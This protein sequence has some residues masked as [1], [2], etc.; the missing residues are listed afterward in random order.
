MTLFLR[1]SSTMAQIA[2]TVRS[3]ASLP[4]SPVFS[5]PSPRR[6]ISAR[7]TIVSQ[8]PSS[9]RSLMLNLTEL[10]PMSMTA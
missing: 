2:E 5:R 7:S 9:R 4:I 8:V 10:V 1:A 3:M 6:V